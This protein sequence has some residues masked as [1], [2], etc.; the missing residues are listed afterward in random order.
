MYILRNSNK[1]K[2]SISANGDKRIQSIYSI[3]TYPYGISK[4]II[5]KNENIKSNNTIRKCDFDEI[6]NENQ[7]TCNPKY[8]CSSDP[9]Y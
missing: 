2:I 6:T 8:P 9:K 3:E 4:D 7:T 5:Y 1:K